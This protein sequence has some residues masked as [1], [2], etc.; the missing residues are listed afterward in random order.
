MSLNTLKRIFLWI[1]PCL[2]LLASAGHADAATWLEELFRGEGG[3][4][5]LFEYGYLLT[6]VLIALATLVS[7]DLTCIGA[8]LLVATGKLDYSSA[9]GACFAGILI[10]DSLVFFAGYFIGRPILK[11]RWARWVIPEKSL[12]RAQEVFKASGVWIILVT[13]FIPGTRTA[14]YF[15]AGVVH[16]PAFKFI[17]IFAIAAMLWTPLLVGLSMVIGNQVADLY[18]SY[19]LLALPAIVLSGVFLYLIVHY[20]IPLFTWKGRRRLK[21]K[22]IRAIRWEYWPIWQV[23]WL[24]FLYVLYLGIFRYR[25]PTLFTATNPSIPHSGFLGESKSAILKSL[26]SAGAKIARWRCI[27]EGAQEEQVTLLRQYM[28]EMELQYPVV[29]KPDEGQRGS[30]VAIVEN[31]MV[32]GD[33]FREHGEAAILQEFVAGIE[34]GI[35]YVRIPGMKDGEITSITLKEQLFITGNGEDSLEDLIYGHP[36]AIVQL[37]MFL[38]RHAPSL[39]TLPEKGVRLPL[40]QLGTHALGSLFLDGSHL[41]TSQLEESVDAIAKACPDFYFGRFDLIAPDEKSLKNGVGLR[42]IELNGITSE[43]THIYDPRHGLWYAWKVLCRHWKIAFQIG[44]EN[45]AKGHPV[46]PFSEF[47][48]DFMAAARRQRK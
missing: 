2:I 44:H 16:A 47:S 38:D 12:D 18:K 13:R 17:G 21:G 39:G 37:D 5:F 15:S 40:G 34:Y 20:G 25:C 14:T 27:P 4:G 29:L 31:E 22:W 8:G 3:S 9:V 33:W 30:G 36:R 10:G 45:A 32:A 6:L 28:E 1:L 23:N 48:R 11:H 35:F 46:S 26:S 7:E 42:V 43:A 19:E 24:V 41:L